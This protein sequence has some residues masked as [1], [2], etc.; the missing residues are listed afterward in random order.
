[1][2]TDIGLFVGCIDVRWDGPVQPFPSLCDVQHFGLPRGKGEIGLK[3][4]AA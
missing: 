3:G 4:Y 1:M 2:P